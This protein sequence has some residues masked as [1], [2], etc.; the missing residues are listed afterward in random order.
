[1]LEACSIQYFNA[2]QFPK[3]AFMQL[4]NIGHIQLTAMLKCLATY[5]TC[6]FLLYFNILSF[7]HW[8]IH[9]CEDWRET[10]QTYTE[11]QQ[12][13]IN[14]VHLKVL[15]KHIHAHTRLQKTAVIRCI[16]A[17]CRKELG[18]C[19]GLTELTSRAMYHC[20]VKKCDAFLL[21]FERG[22]DRKRD[23]EREREMRNVKARWQEQQVGRQKEN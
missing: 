10:P 2:D 20:S 4:M 11:W 3:I 23:I 22:R 19:R 17:T 16:I 1:M 14:R 21:D 18:E 8:Y 6:Q 9:T 12:S 7:T 13:F 15:L 5:S